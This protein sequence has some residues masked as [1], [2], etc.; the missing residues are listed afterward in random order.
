M[1]LRCRG[2]L[3][4][5]LYWS[6]SPLL[7]AFLSAIGHKQK[8]SRG[9]AVFRSVFID[10]R[11]LLTPTPCPSTTPMSRGRSWNA[12]VRAAAASVGAAAPVGAASVDAASVGAAPVG[13]DVVGQ[14]LD[15]GLVGAAWTASRWSS[16]HED[17]ARDLRV[18][19][20]RGRSGPPPSRDRGRSRGRGRP[21]AVGRSREARL[22]QR[23]GVEE[24][25]AVLLVGID[26]IGVANVVVGRGRTLLRRIRLRAAAGAVVGPARGFQTAR[27][28]IRGP[29]LRR[30]RLLSAHD[31]VVTDPPILPGCSIPILL[32]LPQK[33]GV[34]MCMLFAVQTVQVLISFAFDNCSLACGLIMRKKKG[35]YYSWE[36]WK[37]T[38]IHVEEYGYGKIPDQ[39]IRT[40]TRGESMD[41]WDHLTTSMLQKMETKEPKSETRRGNAFAQNAHQR[42]EHANSRTQTG[43]NTRNQNRIVLTYKAKSFGKSS[44]RMPNHDLRIN[45]TTNKSISRNIASNKLYV[46]MN[47]STAK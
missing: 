13:A 40:G 23:P 24:I 25:G 6:M 26:V 29:V 7:V 17:L 12:A 3:I 35:A 46:I 10:E 20:P 37:M 1:L 19:G 16:V 32:P 22:V 21:A 9:V 44:S 27:A 41:V 45:R 39:R 14:V 33:I 42:S 30:R 18:R 31:H 11:V 47:R 28:R 34:I 38:T 8:G 36:S 43:N 4:S 15:G 2:P 5:W